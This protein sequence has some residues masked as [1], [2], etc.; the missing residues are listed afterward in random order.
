MERQTIGGFCVD[1]KK[2]E[3]NEIEL[4]HV[5]GSTSEKGK[6]CFQADRD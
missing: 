2:W 3:P 1:L 4:P 5:E 6:V